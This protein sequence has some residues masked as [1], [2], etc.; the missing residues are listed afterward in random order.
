MT[1]GGLNTLFTFQQNSHR[2]FR[3]SLRKQPSFFARGPSGVLRRHDGILLFLRVL[4]V[5]C[6]TAYRETTDEN[7][8]CF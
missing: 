8:G 5:C 1:L 2:H 7:T 3:R 4:L 6:F